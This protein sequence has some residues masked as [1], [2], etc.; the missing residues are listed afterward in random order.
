M[1]ERPRFRTAG[2]Q[3]EWLLAPG[4]LNALTDVPG[5]RVGHAR[6]PGAAAHTGVTVIIPHPGDLFNEKCR[7]AV[8]T[9][10]GAGECV[11][12]LQIREWGLLETPIFLTGTAG[13][14]RVYDAALDWMLDQDPR[15]ARTAPIVIPVV[16]ECNDG[17]L[18][19]VRTYRAGP[20]EVAAAMA[21]AAAGPVAEGNVGAGSGMVAYGLKAGIGTAS[22]QIP[23]VGYTLGAMVLANFGR[24]RELSIGGV[25]IGA[26]LADLPD[27]R[28]DL[29]I[30]GSA[31]LI[32]ATDAPLLAHDL[33]RVAKRASFGLFRTGS[34]AHH[35]SGEIV[36]AFTTANRVPE[37]D[38]IEAPLVQA[39]GSDLLGLLFTAAVEAAE[40]A[41]LNALCGAETVRSGILVCP[42][43]PVDR[44]RAHLERS[45]PDLWHKHDGCARG[46]QQV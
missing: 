2:M 13:V 9:I 8:Y 41:V 25:R 6:V 44:V 45:R 28:G 29:P 10:N 11:G 19:D 7:A 26:Q 18:N 5:V 1:S 34:V 3:L 46:T 16:A 32:I 35:G 30:D 12:A 40:E 38:R 24:R 37:A 42:A 23:S 36:V 27:P 14:G 17:L 43:L 21:A 39:T 33:R 15:I 22:R 4:P 20:A 31:I